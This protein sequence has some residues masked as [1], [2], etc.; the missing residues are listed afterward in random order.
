MD[1]VVG[2]FPTPFLI[3]GKLLDGGLVASCLED[4][5]QSRK[6][7]NAQTGLLSHSEPVNPQ[8]KPAYAQIA[9]LIAPKLVEFGAVLFGERLA[10]TVKEMWVNVL[11]TGGHQLIH[12]HANSFISGVIYLTPSHPSARTVFHKNIG[13]TNFIFRH[14]GPNVQ[15]GPFNADKWQMPE[16]EPGAMVLFPSYL[17]HEAPVNKGGQ[18]VTIAF[19]AI[20]NSL[21][22][23]GYRVNFA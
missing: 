8:T 5:L 20:P 11:E 19:N 10:W 18:R 15:M 3:V 7:A 1:E 14:A 12:T 6:A 16:V 13:G 22:S 23:W 2:L 9:R 17:L 21:D 4:A